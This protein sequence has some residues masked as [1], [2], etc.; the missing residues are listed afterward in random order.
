MGDIRH[1]IG[2]SSE[3]LDDRKPVDS[4][5]VRQRP[6]AL[7]ADGERI[8]PG[9]LES[10]AELSRMARRLGLDKR[11]INGFRL[12]SAY[13]AYRNLRSRVRTLGSRR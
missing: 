7:G 1:D 2:H 4:L 9:E 12:Y 11:G 8:S 3:G 13:L 10:A 5:A 6:P